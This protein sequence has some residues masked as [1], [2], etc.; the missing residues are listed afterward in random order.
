[1]NGGSDGEG[2]GSTPDRQAVVQGLRAQVHRLVDRCAGRDVLEAGCGEG[3]GAALIAEVAR[4]VI[5][6]DYDESAVAHVR[7]LAGSGAGC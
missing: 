1:M 6:L 5:G 4:S 2:Q 7:A 3:Y